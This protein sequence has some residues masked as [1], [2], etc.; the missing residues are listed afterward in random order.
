MSKSK[1]N[2]VDPFQA[3]KEYGVDGVRW[4]LLRAGGSLADDSGGSRRVVKKMLCQFVLMIPSRLF[5]QA[6]PVELHQLR[7]ADR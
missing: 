5:R 2:V 1:G 7:I 3:M 6:A 4:Y